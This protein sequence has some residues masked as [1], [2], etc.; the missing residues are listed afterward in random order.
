MHHIIKLITNCSLYL[1]TKTTLLNS[2]R[3]TIKFTMEVEEGG[4]L[5]F[6]DTRVTRKEDGK[7]DITVYHKQT[8]M[9]RYLHFRS[10]HPTHVKR[11]MV[12]CLYDR[13]RCITQQGQNLKEEDHLVK[14]FVGNG[15]LCSF[16]RSASTAKPPRE[17]DGE[18]EEERPSTVHLPY[19]AAISEQIRRVCRDFNIRAVFK[20]EPTLRSLF[21]NVKDPLPP[22]GEAS[23]RCLQSAMHL[24]KGIHRRDYISTWNTSEEA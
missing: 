15:Y 5:P 22:C 24:Q 16:I 3:P 12:R 10:H 17:H 18:R 6:L 8:H 2:I 19:V 20:S 21:T 4:S 13:T 14:A 7:L 23:K 11:G 1:L 9:D